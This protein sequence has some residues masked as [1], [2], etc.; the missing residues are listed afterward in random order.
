MVL[1]V[2]SRLGPGEAKDWA[3]G[4]LP[5]FLGVCVG[6]RFKKGFPRLRICRKNFIA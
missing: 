2:V 1:V 3:L 6:K 5:G 4:F